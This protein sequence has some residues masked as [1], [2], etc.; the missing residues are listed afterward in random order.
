MVS[1][2]AKITGPAIAAGAVSVGLVLI[3]ACGV[4]KNDTYVPPPPLKSGPSAA[5]AVQ[6]GTSVTAQKV[7]I[8]P[9]P[10]WQVAPAGPPRR[11]A[12]YTPMTTPPDSE[13]D[14]PGET[15]TTTR[16]RSTPP[17]RSTDPEEP[18]TTRTRPR[19]TEREEPTTTR[20]PPVP[21]TTAAAPP[22]VEETT[23]EAAPVEVVTPI[24]SPMPVPAPVDAPT[25]T[26]VPVPTSTTAPPTE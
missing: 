4:G 17:T 24:E 23:P 12:G 3:G 11:P 6:N 15:E 10:T 25:E 9:S 1:N 26:S 7:V 19:T 8:P 21:T 20:R 16:P 13:I 2:R 18:T 22:P 14:I 5:M